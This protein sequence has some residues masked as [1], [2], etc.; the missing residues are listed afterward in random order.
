M[1]LYSTRIII[2]VAFVTILAIVAAHLWNPAWN[3]LAFG[4]SRESLS[5]G[6]VLIKRS[7]LILIADAKGYF[8]DEGLDVSLKF[9]DSGLLAV[10][11]MLAGKLD[12]S[13]AAPLVVVNK[14]RDDNHPKLKI[15]TE[16]GKSEDIRIVGRKDHGLI[17]PHDLMGKRVGVARGTE[18]EFYLSL[19][20]VF[21]GVPFDSITRVDLGSEG[22]LK[23]LEN[24]EVAAI[25]IWEPIASKAARI[26]GPN[27]VVWAGQGR[28]ASGW[29]LLATPEIISKRPEAIRRVISGLL[30]AEIFISEHEDEAKSIVA[31]RLNIQNV[32]P[33]WDKNDYKIGLSKQ[34][35]SAMELRARW[36]GEDEPGFHVPNLLRSFDFDILKSVAPERI[37][38]IH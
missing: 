13:T 22:Q 37:A 18:P 4:E 26:L 9:Y 17:N 7:A 8:A 32:S 30:T 12:L 23:A 38:I 31:R 21:H 2:P 29:M 11:D 25:I 28:L 6:T 34:F 5:L 20:S 27:A 33:D 3:S 16:V 10:N 14:N 1:R 35:L 36:L 19:F 15:V 24:G